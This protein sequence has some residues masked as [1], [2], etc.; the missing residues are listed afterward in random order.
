MSLGF[1]T[2]NTPTNNSLVFGSD[3]EIYGWGGEQFKREQLHHLKEDNVI[4]WETT[5]PNSWFG[6]GITALFG[7]NMSNYVDNGSLKFKIK[8]PA[9]VTFRI[10]ITDNIYQ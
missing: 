4:A 6:G 8:I 7:K 2:D 3:A 10:G 1:Y 9:D 5:A